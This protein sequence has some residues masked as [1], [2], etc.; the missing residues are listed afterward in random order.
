LSGTRRRLRRAQSYRWE[1]PAA[2]TAVASEH[3]RQHW[4]DARAKSIAWAVEAAR[5]PRVVYL[6]TETTGFG[7]RAEI[8]DIAVVS[9]SG[10]LLF[11]SLVKPERRIPPETS[12]IHGIYDADVRHAPQWDD[13]YDALAEILDGRRILVY[14]VT[15][16]RQMVTQECG[17]YALSAPAADWEC[18][19]KKYA[20]FHGNWDPGK[21]WYK[22]VKL[23]RAVLTFGAEPGGHRA[24]ADAF[25][26][27]AVVLG[28]AA[29]APPATV[30]E[31]VA[32]KPELERPWHVPA[33]PASA[34]RA[35]GRLLEPESPQS[36]PTLLE[37]WAK[38]SREFRELLEDVPSSLH[39]RPGACGTW[40]VR[41]VV[42]HAA[43]WEWEAARRLRLIAANPDLPDANYDVDRFN[44]ANVT[45]RERQGW[46]RTLDE[47]AKASHTFGIAAAAL[48]DDRRTR[49]WLLGRAA[50]FEEHTVGL[51]RWLRESAT[52]GRGSRL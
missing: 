27:R 43:G 51:R 48:P 35:V 10:E 42:A 25:A 39:E 47:L 49:E 11:E 14:N 8:V 33:I 4:D 38:A 28:M 7:P 22:F 19:M 45:V 29:T 44:G 36:E 21:R 20:G 17:R 24:A 5:D 16:D 3:A 31:L 2:E 18:A 40:S 32:V 26:C 12:A 15:F 13:L 1:P 34:L 9:A 30:P 23:E 37:R 52:S 50:D 6:D 46:D 41:E